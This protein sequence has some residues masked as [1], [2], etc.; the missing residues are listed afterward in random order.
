MEPLYGIQIPKELLKG[1]LI[2]NSWPV[3]ETYQETIYR[4]LEVGYGVF[5]WISSFELDRSSETPF[6]TII[7]TAYCAETTDQQTSHSASMMPPSSTRTGIWSANSRLSVPPLQSLEERWGQHRD[8]P[9]ARQ[10]VASALDSIKEVHS[11]YH[12][13]HPSALFFPVSQIH[14]ID[15]SRLGRSDFYFGVQFVIGEEPPAG[16]WEAQLVFH[17]SVGGS[18]WMA[19]RTEDRWAESWDPIDISPRGHGMPKLSLL[20]NMSHRL[21]DTE[22]SI[23]FTCSKGCKAERASSR[24]AAIVGLH[25]HSLKVRAIKISTDVKCRLALEVA[26]FLES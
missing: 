9:T 6:M 18:V 24:I 10:L 17:F 22:E 19:S 12:Q 11:L 4:D 16:A 26:V 13:K 15:L 14:H 3:A 1:P 25:R 8:G 7:Y 21:G 5:I 23:Q 20:P 2:I